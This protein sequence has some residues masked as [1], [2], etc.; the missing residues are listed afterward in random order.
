MSSSSEN[1]ISRMDHPA[2]TCSSPSSSDQQSVLSRRLRIDE[3]K[4][5]RRRF[6]KETAERWILEQQFG[7]SDHSSNGS[8]PEQPIFETT[9]PPLPRKV[10]ERSENF[11]KI[12]SRRTE[13]K[14]AA[15]VSITDNTKHVEMRNAGAERDVTVPSTTPTKPL[16][17]RNS[18]LNAFEFFSR[19]GGG[20]GGA[21]GSPEDNPTEDIP[22]PLP[23]PRSVRGS[24]PNIVSERT[25]VF[26]T[27]A[28]TLVR[29]GS[30]GS[31]TQPPS[32]Q[33]TTVRTTL[34]KFQHPQPDH[35]NTTSEGATT[36]PNNFVKRRSALRLDWEKKEDDT[37]TSSTSVRT[38]VGI[39]VNERRRRGNAT[40]GI[41]DGELHLRDQYS[42][43]KT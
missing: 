31:N 43:G 12:S 20:S 27:S 15:A 14:T 7:G 17:D 24:V 38:K 22:P 30:A 16:T 8:A 28:S 40:V 21:A 5:R 41:R 18:F 9:A 11:I 6:H 26:C 4:E 34:L 19:G 13:E 37:S 10:I 25:G 42:Q 1:S 32:K 2:A 36:S 39:F 3:I 23:K 35:D 29:S 33:T